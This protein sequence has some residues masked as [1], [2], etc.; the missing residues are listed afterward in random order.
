MN[1]E[2]IVTDYNKIVIDE[3]EQL[4]KLSDYNEEVRSVKLKL[5][6][7][8]KTNAALNSV[9]DLISKTES[10]I[11]EAATKQLA[12][13][14]PLR[15]SSLNLEMNTGELQRIN[16]FNFYNSVKNLALVKQ[17]IENSIT[18]NQT[19]YFNSLLDII[20]ANRPNEIELSKADKPTRDFYN[21]INS[22]RLQSDND[23]K[24]KELRTA[25]NELRYIVDAINS[26]DSFLILPRT[27]KQMKQ[28]EINQVNAEY[29]NRAM[30]YYSA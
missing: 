11:K 22:L 30:K 25:L 17:E 27:I 4:R 16:A 2:K 18:T 3:Q 7:Q 24:V 28:N 1:I 13:K 5:W 20:E 15:Y 23:S 26:G 8:E 21:F 19:D 6:K 9:N 10:E 29:L 14:Y 12:K